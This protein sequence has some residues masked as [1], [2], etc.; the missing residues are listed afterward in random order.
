M[1]R[2]TT[3]GWGK[4]RPP[5]I[6]FRAL[7]A[8]KRLSQKLIRQEKLIIRIKCEFHTSTLSQKLHYNNNNIKEKNTEIEK[9]LIHFSLYI[10]FKNSRKHFIQKICFS[11]FIFFISYTFYQNRSC[12]CLQ[13]AEDIYALLE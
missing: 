3:N 5:M 13:S 1:F 9:H 7:S 4:Q 2:A 8:D 10:S 11:C 12:N 6:F